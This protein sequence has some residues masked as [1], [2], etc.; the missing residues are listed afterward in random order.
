MVPSD[1][2]QIRDMTG[3]VEFDRPLWPYVLLGIATLIAAG[4][5]WYLIRRRR[6]ADPSSVDE[7][8]LVDEPS[9]ASVA[10]KRL[11]ALENA[12]LSNRPQVELFYVE[13]SDTLRTYVEHR[14][15]IPAL[16]STTFELI[17]DLVHPKIQHQ[18]PAGIPNQLEQILSLADLVKFADLTPEVNQGRTALEEAI[19]VI[20]RVETKFDQRA[21]SEQLGIKH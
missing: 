5:I 15:Q 14:L 18:I 13:L 11:D 12:P 7:P 8:A 16:E 21:A 3:P 1:A 6:K 10:L 9:P 17:Q 4:L 20:Q 19:Q 2:T